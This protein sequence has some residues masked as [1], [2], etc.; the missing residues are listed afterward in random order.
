MTDFYLNILGLKAEVFDPNLRNKDYKYD[1][2]IRACCKLMNKSWDEVSYE[3]FEIG[4]KNGTVFN[5]IDP[6]LT[7]Y[8]SQFDNSYKLVLYSKKQEITCGEYI[9]KHK[10]N[11]MYLIGDQK[12]I[13]CCDGERIY[14]N[15]IGCKNIDFFLLNP[16]K[17]VFNRRVIENE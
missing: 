12:H 1:C 13:V 7:E 6:V 9:Y 15:A 10:T 8:V 2:A 14:D 4:K 5:A 11:G 3:L 16:V 17:Y